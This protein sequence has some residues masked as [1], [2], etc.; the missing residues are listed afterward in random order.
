VNARASIPPRLQRSA[1]ILG[2]AGIVV[3][4][5]GAAID[6]G[7]FMRAYFV[8]LMVFWQL[9]LGCLAI[10]IGYHLMGGR[11]G[12]VIGDALEAGVRTVPL[13]GLLFLPV[14]LDLDA[15]Y[16]WARAGF[17]AEHETVA[18]KLGWLNEPFFI[19]RSLLYWAIWIGLAFALTTPSRPVA[20]RPL[21]QPIAAAGAVFYALT[22]TFASIDWMMSLEPAF[23][24][25]IYGL[26]VMSGQAVAAFALAVL[27]T[28]WI[29][30]VAGRISHLREEGL[31]G[32]GTLLYALVLL[33]V[34]HAFMQLLVIWSGNLPHDAEWYLVRLEGFWRALAW[35]IGIGH[36][37][38]PFLIFL[39]S[40]ARQSWRVVTGMAVLLLVMRLLDQL[41]LVLPAFRDQQTPPWLVAAAL[42]VVGGIWL[43][44]FLWLIGNRARW[45]ARTVEE[46]G[47]G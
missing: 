15:L 3:L 31:I 14:L 41:W 24:S 11:W 27:I 46:A 44:A 45:V 13:L 7:A 23:N 18:N 25:T 33:W 9:P 36:F 47:G 40:R 42:A 38:L 30:E 20:E 6:L 37:A 2:L 34:Y 1:L 43:A 22:V 29:S 19:A 8:A 26:V 10:L 5:F 32:L 17:V 12:V 28:L 35:A 16:P 4:A 39:S 21:R